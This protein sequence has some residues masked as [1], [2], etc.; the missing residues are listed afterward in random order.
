MCGYCIEGVML[1]FIE[2]EKASVKKGTLPFFSL[3][4]EE[5]L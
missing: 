3:H 5:L 4:L 1:D 2:H